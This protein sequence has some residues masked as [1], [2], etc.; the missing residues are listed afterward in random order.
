[1][2]AALNKS[3]QSRVFW[4]SI[5]GEGHCERVRRKSRASCP[6]SVEWGPHAILQRC[7]V[8]TATVL[9]VICTSAYSPLQRCKVPFGTVRGVI[10]NGARWQQQRSFLSSALELT[11]LYNGARFPLV[12]C[13]SLF[14]DVFWIFYSP[15]ECWWRTPTLA[16]RS[17]RLTLTKTVLNCVFNTNQ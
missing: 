16:K 9:P 3:L 6:H 5:Q 12:R 15:E 11:P 14:G 2:C 4:V 1:M 17:E 13:S 7:E 10:T 8:S